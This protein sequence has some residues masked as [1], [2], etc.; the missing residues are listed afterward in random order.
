MQ[1]I[2]YIQLQIVFGIM[3]FLVIII[4]SLVS[5][6]PK[7]LKFSLYSIQMSFDVKGKQFQVIKLL[8]LYTENDC[9]N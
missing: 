8:N 6:S 4:Q 7:H 1:S 2:V 5:E 3:T 9:F